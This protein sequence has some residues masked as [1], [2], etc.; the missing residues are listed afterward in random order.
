[1][2]SERLFEAQGF[3]LIEALV[4]MTVFAIGSM[5]I[6][7][8]MFTWVR[9]NAVSMQRDQA[10]QVLDREADTLAAQ[11]WDSTEWSNTT[12]TTSSLNDAI[13]NGLNNPAYTNWAAYN[14]SQVPYDA[15]TNVGY[16]VVGVTNSVGQEVSRVM[17]VRIQW[18]GPAGN[19]LQETRLIQRNDAP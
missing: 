15:A 10:A 11:S 13:Q 8:S 14:A 17:K 2:A 18:T 3:T 4:A 5:M 19:Q 7:P 9:A 16:A 12:S 1:M 6:V